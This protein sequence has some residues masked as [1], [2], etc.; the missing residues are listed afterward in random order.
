[1]TDHLAGA[2]AALTAPWDKLPNSTWLAATLT[3]QRN[4]ENFKFP[5]KL[6]PERRQQVISLASKEL[7]LSKE[8]KDPVLLKA[9]EI[10]P[11]DKEYLSE[12][13]LSMQSFQQA[14]IGEGFIVDASGLFLIPL[15]MN[16]HLQ[17]TLLDCSGDLEQALTRLVGVE[18]AL[19][20]SLHYAFSNKFGFLTADPH[21]AGT[22]FTATIF[23]HLPALAQSGSLLTSIK[24]P[25]DEQ[26]TFTG[27][28][29]SPTEIIGDIVALQNNFTLAVTE[30]GT[31]TA[32]KNAATRLQVLENT[33]RLKLS[34]Q[35][36][37]LVK[38]H[39]SRAFGLL[40]HSYQLE[41]I[42]ALNALSL[43]KLGV[44]LGW[45]VGITVAEV[46]KLFFSCRRAHLIGRVTG[47]VAPEVLPHRRA[48][49]IHASLAKVSL[50]I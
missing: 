18:A 10:A 16:N 43:L 45:V 36:N 8:L 1:M 39:V 35:E 42:E 24:K 31:L 27:M 32:L 41:A 6:T 30:E 47:P 33:A 22:A 13:F 46:H 26:V 17:F 28:S 12:H 40:I 37:P 49:H 15:N 48:E 14:H 7:L 21:Q 23:L 25:D 11:L 29:G 50:A 9:E 20:S 2:V 19:G 4:L 5:G 44:D 34:E 38:D 3:L